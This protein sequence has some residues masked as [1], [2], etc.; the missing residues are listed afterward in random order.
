MIRK[1]DPLENKRFIAQAIMFW[2]AVF[3]MVVMFMAMTPYTVFLDDIKVTCLRVLGP[4]LVLGYLALLSMDLVEIPRRRVLFPLLAY[5]LVM[6]VSTFIAGPSKDFPDRQWTGWQEV[7]MQYCLLGP[8][9][10]FFASTVNWKWMRRAFLFFMVATLFSA[11]FGL[12]HRM[13][14]MGEIMEATRPNGLEDNRIPFLYGMSASFA[15][16]RTQMM[17]FI[18]NRD[19]YGSFLAMMIPLSMGAFFLQRRLFWQILSAVTV[20]LAGICLILTFSKDSWADTF[21]ALA[22]IAFLYVAVARLPIKNPK[23]ILAFIGSMVVVGVTTV[24]MTAPIFLSQIKSFSISFS[25]RTIIW[26]GA[27]RIWEHFPILGGGPGSYRILFPMYRRPDYFLND[28]SHVTTFAHNYFLDVLSETGILG[29]AAML[30]FLG[31]IFVSLFR[32]LR[33]DSDGTYKI[34]IICMI[35]GMTGFL[36]N[37]I[38]SPN[39][40]WPIGGINFWAL[41]GLMAAAL[42]YPAGTETEFYP[43][44][45]QPLSQLGRMSVGVLLVLSLIYGAYQAV[46]GVNYMRAAM[47]NHVGVRMLG[48]PPDNG[49]VTEDYERINQMREQLQNGTLSPAQKRETETQLAQAKEDYN[50]YRN[51]AMEAFNT[52]VKI[53]PTFVTSYYKLANLFFMGENAEPTFEDYDNARKTYMKLQEYWPEYS[54]T[55]Q[56]LGSV[57]FRLAVLDEQA[58]RPETT[59]EQKSQ[60]SEYLKL[61]YQHFRRTAEMTIDPDSQRLYFSLLIRENDWDEAVKASAKLVQDWKDE[62]KG[63]NRMSPEEQKEMLTRVT[64]MYVE[65]ANAAKKDDDTL[66]GLMM[67]YDLN[68]MDRA[69]MARVYQMYEQKKDY[70]GMQKFLEKTL[71]VNPTGTLERY[72]LGMSLVEQGKLREAKKQALMLEKISPLNADQDY[73]LYRV[74][75]SAG[76]MTKAREYAGEFVKH[77]S[78]KIR[79]EEVQEFL[80]A[81]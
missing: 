66:K 78:D 61:A 45:R 79:T 21:L 6:I 16:A 17:S 25:S 22:I 67:L 4:A 64:Q 43:L 7:G 73:L 23:K 49:P 34:A 62:F 15:G 51:M 70:A 48:S 29:L 38:T 57:Y 71:Q 9:L 75:R 56:N 1:I 60:K 32:K 47:A 81:K 14:V 55:P 36:L 11:I 27:I 59:P 41:L 80:N 77:Q 20:P 44:R 30:A 33:K 54:Q 58:K 28:I 26:G 74:Y 53:D 12:C 65:I 50:A 52:A 76:D 42:H 72:W 18:L 3:F 19:F 13:G 35:A 69:G 46:W 31:V 2:M 40:R 24:L 10:V 68:P 5:F 8:F 37:N 63:P 39:V